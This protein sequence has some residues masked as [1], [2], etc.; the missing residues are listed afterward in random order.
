MQG[1][2]EVTSDQINLYRLRRSGLVN[3]FSS[4]EECARSLIGAQAQIH[5]AGGLALWNRLSHKEFTLKEY[6]RKLYEDRSLVKIWGQRGTLH[7]YDS[8][9]WPLIVGSR[10]NKPTWSERSIANKGGDVEG[11]HAIVNKVRKLA[12]KEGIVSRSMLRDL[13]VNWDIGVDVDL[14]SSWGGIFAQ[15]VSDGTM[16]HDKPSGGEGRFAHRE[17]WLPEMV[18]EPPTRDDANV[19]LARRFL[20]TFGPA[21]VKDY[22]YWRGITAKR[23]SEG[24][25]ALEDE[26]SKVESGAMELSILRKDLDILMES[27]PPKIQ[28]PVKLLYRFDPLLLGHKDKSW[29]IDLKHYNKVWIPAGHINGTILAGGRIQGTWNYKRRGGA[30][31]KMGRAGEKGKIE[32]VRGKGNTGRTGT[33]EIEVKPFRKFGKRLM[34]K[35]EREAKGVAEFFGAQ[36]GEINIQELE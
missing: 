32:R 26:M 22:A 12:G 14:L 23:A 36:L 17:H 16:C 33:L 6:E 5:T 9:D 25:G 13:D 20:H 19:E 31:G 11:F 30:P 7:V 3:P 18:W 21:T 35:V 1:P 29:I 28:W 34:R 27:P 15:L 24:F 10:G 4:P 2:M 8:K